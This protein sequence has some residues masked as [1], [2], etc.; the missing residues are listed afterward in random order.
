M[1]RTRKILSVLAA[2]VVVVAIAAFVAWRS[3]FA[4]FDISEPTNIY[5]RPATTAADLRQQVADRCKPASMLGWTLLS[6]AFPF[7]PHTGCY[8]VAPDDD[9][10]I[11][12]RRL[13]RGQQTPVRLTIPSVRRLSRLAGVLGN[14][15]M[16]D[17]AEVSEA[18]A[19]ST[20]AAK[21]GY[22][23]A[24]LPSLFIPNTYEV[25][26]DTSLD[27]LMSRMQRENESFWKAEGRDEA[28]QALGFTHEEVATLASI[29]DEETNYG[30]ER[31]RIAGLYLNRLHKNMPLQADPTVKFAVG[32]DGLR[33]ILNTHL[34]I[35]SPYNTYLNTGLPP[36]PIR[37]ATIASIDAVLN[38]EHHDYLYFCAREDFSGSHNFARTY[39]E[40]MANARK[41]QRALNERGIRK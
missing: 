6:R 15:L 8:T 27:K 23:I 9:L 12:Y 39:A 25:Y 20:F 4:T 17:S 14:N 2:V 5:V 13:S 3:L 33:R 16:L 31:A 32:D 40:H 41:Y 35:A 30:P 7:T 36:G 22:S 18:F 38:A 37:I 19:D 21:L 24:T 1:S 26:W 28:A 11:V 10:L 29:I 34:R